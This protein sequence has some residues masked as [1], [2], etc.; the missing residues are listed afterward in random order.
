MECSIHH[1]K[2]S[3]NAC[4]LNNEQYK[5]NLHPQPVYTYS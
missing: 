5:Y 1:I 3:L 4:S 2:N